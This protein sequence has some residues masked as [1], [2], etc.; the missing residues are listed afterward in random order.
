MAAFPSHVLRDAAASLLIHRP[1]RC[2]HS[3][4]RHVPRRSWGAPAQ[5]RT[6]QGG[7]GIKAVRFGD[8]E[9]RVASALERGVGAGIEEEVN[10]WELFGSQCSV[11]RG[12]G[13]CIRRKGVKVG[14]MRQEN[15]RGPRSTEERSQVQRGPTICRVAIGCRRIV[16]ENFLQ[17]LHI[18]HGSRFV[19]G[20][21]PRLPGEPTRGL[22]RA[23]IQGEEKGCFTSGSSLC[24]Q[25]GVGLDDRAHALKVVLP[26]GVKQFVVHEP[27]WCGR[28]E[29]R[30]AALPV[31]E[32]T[33]LGAVFASPSP[34]ESRRE[35]WAG[36]S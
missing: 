4:S 29:A 18:I 34:Q 11:Q 36:A 33:H 31:R 12:V 13:H 14:A 22:S 8:G 6:E 28:Q 17:T 1:R 30:S 35:P 15:C 27:V 7:C 3:L 5:G 9:R 16:A 24:Q 20:A 21:H 10:Q 26:T 19:D 25:R 23:M 2:H 32:I